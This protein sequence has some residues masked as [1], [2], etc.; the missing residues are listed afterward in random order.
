MQYFNCGPDTPIYNSL[1]HLLTEAKC[2]DMEYD[3][4]MRMSEWGLSP[5]I[6][7]Y[8]ALIN[9]FYDLGQ[10]EDAKIHVDDMIDHGC[11]LNVVT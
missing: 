11:T 3:I 2:M 7:T 5:D 1:I 9:G 10:I 8:N 4:L 6:I